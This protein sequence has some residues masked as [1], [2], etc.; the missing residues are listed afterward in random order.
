MLLIALVAVT[1]AFFSLFRIGFSPAPQITFRQQATWESTET[2]L[3]R[4]SS[5]RFWSG[6]GPGP[7]PAPISGPPPISLASVFGQLA[8]SAPLRRLL[9]KGGPLHGRYEVAATSTPTGA[10][11]P[12]LRIE[13]Q[14]ASPAQAAEIAAR[15]SQTL[16]LYITQQQTN[17]MIPPIQ[18]V[19]LETINAPRKPILIQGHWRKSP[20]IALS[21]VM[22]LLLLAAVVKFAEERRA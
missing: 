3:V 7:G 22:G 4:D 15:V 8:Y 1:L 6:P 19:R 9:L 20:L 12:L 5:P 16:R 18:R 17:A 10:L 21:V 14:A 11:L 2:V 13:G